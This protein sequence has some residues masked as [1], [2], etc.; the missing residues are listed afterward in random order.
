MHYARPQQG[1]AR[2]SPQLIAIGSA[3][4]DLTIGT[5]AIL[6]FAGAAQ[7]NQL[8]AGLPA[9]A[10]AAR[11]AAQ[12]GYS[13]IVI[14]AP[15]PWSAGR[16]LE[17]EVARLASGAVVEFAVEAQAVQGNPLGAV[18]AGG[19]L[20]GGAV[21][22]TVVRAGEID[23]AELAR[24]RSQGEPSAIVGRRIVRATAKDGDGIVSRHINRPISQTISR[25]LLRLPW[26]RPVHATWGT[27]LLAVA[28]LTALLLGTRGGLVA[29][30]L[31]F[32]AA[33][34][35]D[36]VDGEIARATFRTTPQGARLDSL[37]DAAT[38]FACIGGVALNLHF[39]GFTHAALAGAAGLAMLVTGL[40]VIGLRSRDDGNGL[41]FNAVK[42]HFS[43]R[44][45]RIM[46]WLT[47][48]T[49]R[50][51]FAFAGAVLIVAGLAH[52]ALYAFAIVAAGWLL[53]VIA[54]MAR[55]S[56]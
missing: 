28:M 55:Q 23:P 24:L 17:A 32:Q 52:F 46:Q 34:V 21:P 8:V 27:A 13:H 12:G 7:A 50:D 25:I 2:F 37:I 44:R 26:I 38:N 29:G 1:Q 33:S 31:L 49:M 43:Q 20:L 18:L 39:Q 11:T 45:S 9:A 22:E 16:E 6:V 48:L 14:T 40:T 51:F 47:W 10:R 41:T 15:E 5:T 35:F 19:E 54:V 30:A 42:V 4:K 3:A 53:V 56:A 36:G